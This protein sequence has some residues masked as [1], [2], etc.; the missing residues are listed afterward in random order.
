MGEMIIQLMS[1]FFENRQLHG[2]PM[3]KSER[4][5]GGGGEGKE[6]VLSHTSE[7]GEKKRP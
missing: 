1:F 3:W 7:E 6:G 2:C 5:E 4:V